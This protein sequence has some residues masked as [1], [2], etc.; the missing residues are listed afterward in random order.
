[1]IQ[2]H[3][4]DEHDNSDHSEEVEDEFDDEDT[5]SIQSGDIS[6]IPGLAT[7]VDHSTKPFICNKPNCGKQY[8]KL[9]GLI[10]HH[11][12]VH[13]TAD[14]D[15]DK[16]IPK[17]KWISLSAYHMEHGHGVT[18]EVAPNKQRRIESEN[19]EN[20]DKPFI[21]T[22]PCC[23]KAYKTANGLAYHLEKGKLTGHN[24]HFQDQKPYKCPAE[25]C[26]KSYRNQGGLTHHMEKAHRN[27][28]A[29]EAEKTGS[30]PI[31]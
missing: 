12:T 1:E 20:T 30:H 18:V 11:T 10:F 22:H 21:C 23:G 7:L 2:N 15:S 19:G 4:D 6:F 31:N 17:F 26:P 25:D 3:S 29:V 9:N 5:R 28:F 16:P 24:G 8:R 14:L 13:V 27:E